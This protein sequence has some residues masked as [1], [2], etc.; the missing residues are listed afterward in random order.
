ML[1]RIAWIVMVSRKR[2]VFASNCMSDHLEAHEANRQE[3]F[4]S[5]ITLLLLFVRG[6]PKVLYIVDG[7]YVKKN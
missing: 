2:G 4:C 5:T 3:Q 1:A 7:K 6:L